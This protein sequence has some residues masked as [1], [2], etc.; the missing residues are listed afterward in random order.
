MF[1]NDTAIYSSASSHLEIELNLQDDLHS[2]SQWLLHNR[3][4]INAKKSKVMLIGA[5]NKLRNRPELNLY[6]NQVRLDNVNEYLYLGVLLD[7]GLKLNSQM[8]YD[9]CVQKLGLIAKTHH[10]FDQQTSRLL[11]LEPPL[12]IEVI[13]SWN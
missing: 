7:S 4:R 1:A 8:V 2:V 10:L 11:Y 5:N 9:K 13:L 12:H 3:L 6:I